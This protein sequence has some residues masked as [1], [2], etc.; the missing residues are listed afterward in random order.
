MADLI[1][2]G[3]SE[4]KIAQKPDRMRS[5][6][7]GSCVAVVLYTEV[8]GLAAMAHVML[9]DH[10]LAKADFH[11]AKFADTAVPGLL[12]MLV[13]R[14]A[15][16]SDIKAKFAGGAEMFPSVQSRL[17]SVGSRNIAAVEKA[18]NDFQIPIIAQDTGGHAGRTIEF[19]TTTGALH[20]RTVKSGEHDI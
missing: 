9:P 5:S 13:K 1:S 14:G 16:Q 6:G 17:P 20:I 11:P 3:I 18:L 4:W 8:T 10:H 19:N 12:E 2:V 15:R 7:L